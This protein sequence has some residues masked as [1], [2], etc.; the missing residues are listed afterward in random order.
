MKAVQYIIGLLVLTCGIQFV[1]A[2]DFQGKAIYESK[3]SIQADFGPRDMPEARKQEIRERMKKAMERTYELTFD[4]TSSTYQQEEKLEAPSSGGGRFR[5]AMFGGGAGEYYKNVKDVQYANQTE[6]FGKVFLIQDS[7]P[8]WDWQLGSETKKIGSYTCYKA[9]AT[10]PAEADLFRRM[11]PPPPGREDRPERDEIEKDSTD[12]NSLF[13]QIDE[14]E[15][16]IITVWYTP[17]IPVS[18]GPGQYWGLPGLILE[19]ND[20]R[21]AI[22]CSKLILNPEEKISI[23]APSKGKKVTQEEFDE[24]VAQKMEEMRKRFEGERR[25]GGNRIMVRG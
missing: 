22:L 19:V 7:L 24:I 8:K 1:A 5:M 4:R 21:T 17:E 12:Q 13:A 14:P 18:Q 3:T 16:Q 2:Q 11:M 6:V 9:T 15:E 25:R 23:E 20:G 10:Q